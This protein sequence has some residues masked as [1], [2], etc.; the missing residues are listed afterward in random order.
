MILIKGV[1]PAAKAIVDAICR[2]ERYVTEPSWYRALHLFK[3]LCPEIADWCFNIVYKKLP[4]MNGEDSTCNASVLTL[5][6]KPNK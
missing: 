1:S 6:T 5:G 4:D 3:F 2:G